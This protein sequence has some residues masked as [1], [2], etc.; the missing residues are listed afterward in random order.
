MIGNDFAVTLVVVT[1]VAEQANVHAFGE[2]R[3]LVQSFCGL[4]RLKHARV[5]SLELRKVA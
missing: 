2:L 1:L 4:L 3:N 5:N